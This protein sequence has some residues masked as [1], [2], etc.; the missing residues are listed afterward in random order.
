MG[1]L[2]RWLR[3][4]KAWIDRHETPVPREP[5]SMDCP[6][7]GEFGIHPVRSDFRTDWYCESCYPPF[8]RRG[9]TPITLAGDPR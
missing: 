7:C 5:H 2:D 3:R 9:G 4:V 6:S 1:I 8:L